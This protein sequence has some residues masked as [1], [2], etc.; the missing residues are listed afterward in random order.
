MKVS[1]GAA[2]ALIL[3]LVCSGCAP[4]RPSYDQVRDEAIAVLEQ[5]TALLPGVSTPRPR[6]ELKPY[7]C[8]SDLLSGDGSDSAFYTGYWEVEVEE[9][10]DVEKF[11]SSLQSKLGDQWEVEDLGIPVSFPQIHLVRESPYISL[12]VEERDRHGKNGVDLLVMS[13]CGVVG[14]EDQ[15]SESERVEE[16]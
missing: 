3:V 13:R 11:I 7:W 14:G 8:G 2:L 5:V 12:T 15:G 1:T 16:R 4:G 6:P 9:T 10:L